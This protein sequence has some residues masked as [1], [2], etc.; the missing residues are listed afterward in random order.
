MTELELTAPP[1]P[2]PC[3]DCRASAAAAHHGFRHGCK[4]CTARSVSRSQEFA[5]ARRADRRTGAGEALRDQYRV[6]LEITGITHDE[7]LAAW[8]VDA[9]NRA[10][11]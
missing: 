10:E 6:L 8:R 7:A 4:G 9:I 3:P 11:A 5:L 1:A 2:V